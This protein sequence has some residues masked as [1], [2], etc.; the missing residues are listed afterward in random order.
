MSMPGR[1]SANLCP[2]Y[3]L[4]PRNPA[5]GV[6]SSPAPDAQLRIIS[7]A[8]QVLGIVVRLTP[9]A[10]IWELERRI[11]DIRQVREGRRHG[12]SGRDRWPESG[13]RAEGV[14]RRA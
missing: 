3:R 4:V 6:L 12:G 11:I 5:A 14:C 13:P 7:A 9:N 2:K 10:A 8:E 1:S